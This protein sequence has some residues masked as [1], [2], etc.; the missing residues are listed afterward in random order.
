[1]I[2]DDTRE[3]PDASPS[4]ERL[5][6]SIIINTYNRGSILGNA[7]RSL[8]QLRH[9]RFEAVVVNGPSTDNS[10]EVIASHKKR[11][12]ALSCPEANLSMSRNIG[13]LAARGDICC[14]MDDDA[15][16]EP[17]WL[18]QL[19]TAYRDPTVGGVGG[20]TRDHTGVTFQTRALLCDQYGDSQDFKTLEEAEKAKAGNSDLYYS[21]TGTNSSFR[22]TALMEIGG[23][24]E[25]FVYFLDETDVNFRMKD[26]GWKVVYA[27]GAEIHHKYAPSH[28]RTEKRI[29]KSL[30]LPARSKSYFILRNGTKNHDISAPLEKIAEYELHIREHNSWY[31]KNDVLDEQEF[32]ALQTSLSD[33]V[34]AGI[35]AAFE[36]N[37]REL[38]TEDKI[39]KFDCGPFKPYPTPLAP[40]ERLKIAFLSQTYPPDMAGGIGI[41]THA[42]ATSLADMGHEVSVVTQ[43]TRGAF[44]TVDFEDGVWVHRITPKH[45]P[46]R[47]SPPLPDL[48]QITKDR[49][50]TTYDE[51]IR[52]HE[53]RGLDV[54]SAPIWDLEGFAVLRDGRLPVVTSLHTTFKL[55]LPSKPD[56]FEMPGYKEQHVD[57]IIAGELTLLKE[58]PAILGN[59][60]A[61]C[62]DIKEAY[63]CEI[64]DKLTIIPHGLRD[65]RE[66]FAALSPSD[67]FP[68][69]ADN[70]TRVLFVGRFEDRKGVVELLEAIEKVAPQ[71]PDIEFVLVGDNDIAV[72]GETH[73]RRFLARNDGREFLSRVKAV[74]AVS[75]EDLLRHYN[76]CD[77]FV[78]PSR[79][80]S[81]GL[82]FVEA[83][84]FGKPCIGTNI[85]G[86]SEVV[87]HEHTGL[88]VEPNDPEA[89]SAAILSLV[90]NQSMAYAMG[91]AGRRRYEQHFHCAKMAEAALA[92]YWMTAEFLGG[93]SPAKRNNREIENV[94]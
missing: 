80:E 46:L 75:V 64:D 70:M 71:R 16:P 31:V 91:L 77:I 25:H 47:T 5:S 32:D 72:R 13:I 89:L 28:L 1:M 10:A 26:A 37:E 40:S 38:I 23:F 60:E 27:P 59:S 54:V 78:A 17:D 83:M 73:W 58:S 62:R 34:L 79:Y 43:Q 4:A 92:H 39:A 33:G 84:T 61:V 21:Q 24:D 93:R 7:L 49:L 87:A 63:D 67:E 48:S 88:L 11:I 44:D 69:K 12:K 8:A 56:W 18:D 57:K 15:V 86:I 14:F 19:E 45:Q 29:P 81:F 51:I 90:D 2:A 68:D 74:G 53:R 36:T 20:F 76:A 66:S 9:P 50:Y 41:W 30:Y 22:R 3:K 35:T 52:I 42:M 65:L 82:I 55:C 94:L 85:G 6:F